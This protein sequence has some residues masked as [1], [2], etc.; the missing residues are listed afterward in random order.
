MPLNAL[1]VNKFLLLML[2]KSYSCCP[3]RLRNEMRNALE[4]S[5]ASERKFNKGN[6][7]PQTFSSVNST[8][9]IM[10]FCLLQFCLNETIF[11]TSIF[12]CLM[13][14]CECTCSQNPCFPDSSAFVWEYGCLVCPQAQRMLRGMCWP[15]Y[16]RVKAKK[17]LGVKDYWDIENGNYREE[18]NL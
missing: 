11:Y 2:E 10:F 4:G 7:E 5:L 3:T 8:R 1:I 12:C 6:T 16:S 17:L 18:M 14:M 9:Y 15:D 13:C